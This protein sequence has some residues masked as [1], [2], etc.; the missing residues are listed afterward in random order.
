[1]DDTYAAVWFGYSTKSTYD[2]R[3]NGGDDISTFANFF[4]NLLFDEVAR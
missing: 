2:E 4:I 1:M 3:F